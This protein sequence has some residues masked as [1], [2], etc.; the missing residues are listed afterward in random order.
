[1]S[2]AATFIVAVALTGAA[3][4]APVLMAPARAVAPVRRPPRR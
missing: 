1:M 2:I 4:L 3:L